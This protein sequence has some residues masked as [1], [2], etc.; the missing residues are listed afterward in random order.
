V[1]GF[2]GSVSSV[3]ELRGEP[4]Q[5]FS[6]DCV[7]NLYNLAK[8]QNVPVKRRLKAAGMDTT[9]LCAGMVIWCS[10]IFSEPFL[11]KRKTLHLHWA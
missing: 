10:E 9:T 8:L 11:L 1:A 6:F 7:R 2:L 4:A 5:L 3:G